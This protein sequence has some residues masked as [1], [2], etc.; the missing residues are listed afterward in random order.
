MGK[1]MILYGMLGASGLAAAL[2][3]ARP[4]AAFGGPGG[5]WHGLGGRFGHHRMSPA[6]IQEHLQVGVKWALRDV[7]ASDDQQARVSAILGAAVTDLQRLKETHVENRDAFRAA[8]AGPAVDRDALERIR[9]AELAL[10]EDASRRVVQA[11]ADAAE[12]L[13]P[14]QRAALAARHDHRR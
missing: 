3:V 1:K 12:A 9:K 10:A 5:G 8:L 13:T 6:A 2:L 11:L 7:G 4:I 14:E